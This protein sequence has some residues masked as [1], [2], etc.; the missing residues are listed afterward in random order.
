MKDGDWLLSVPR[1]ASRLAQ[2]RNDPKRPAD[3][4]IVLTLDIRGQ[5]TQ[6]ESKQDVQRETNELSSA[7][8][9]N[10]RAGRERERTCGA[11]RY[12]NI[13]NSAYTEYT[14]ST[15]AVSGR[16]LY[17]IARGRVRSLPPIFCNEVTEVID[18]KKKWS[19][20]VQKMSDTKRPVE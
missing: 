3:S 18:L 12:T 16:F 8:A 15:V 13:D 19:P 11:C 7:S 9:S 17:V 5:L 20:P 1:T 14:N 10:L 2:A 6:R 4:L